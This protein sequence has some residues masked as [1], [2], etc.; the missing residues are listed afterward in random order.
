MGVV[1][2]YINMSEFRIT[3]PQRSDQKNYYAS[4]CR[5]TNKLKDML[6]MIAERERG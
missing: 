5:T 1:R 6:C 3:L 2:R 4:R